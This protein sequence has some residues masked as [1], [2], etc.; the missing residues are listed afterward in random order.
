[1]SETTNEVVKQA[2]EKTPEEIKREGEQKKQEARIELLKEE[3][4]KA[5]ETIINSEHNFTVAEVGFLPDIFK[6]WIT[7]RTAATTEHEELLK[8]EHEIGTAFNEKIV[9]ELNFIYDES[10]GTTKEATA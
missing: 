9:K 2:P 7:I 5:L 10:T 1:M 3:V 6:Q 4:K 8:K